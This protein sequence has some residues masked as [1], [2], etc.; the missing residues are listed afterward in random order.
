M[1]S[2]P[3]TAPLAR[4]VSRRGTDSGMTII[5]DGLGEYEATADGGIA[6]TLVRSVGALSRN[7]LPERPGHAGWPVPTPGAQLLG[8]YRAAF[9]LLPHGPASNDAI[10][11]IERAADDALLPLVGTTLTSALHAIEPVAGLSLEG[12][13]LR[14]L[15][16]KDSEDGAW[17]V[18]RCVNLVSHGVSG[19]WRCGW[20]VGEARASRLD[21]QPGQALAVRDGLVEFTLGPSEVGTVLVR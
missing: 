10:S 9:A 4:W 16:C 6:I 19:S 12:D 17:T 8:P 11:E 3:A 20:P 1:E 14:F 15:A 18:L 21:E 13:G 5:S 7:D 2:I